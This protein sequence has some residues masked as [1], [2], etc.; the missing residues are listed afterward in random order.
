MFFVSVRPI[1]AT[2]FQAISPPSHPTSCLSPVSNPST[3]LPGWRPPTTVLSCPLPMA[4]RPHGDGPRPTDSPDRLTSTPAHP[5]NAPRTFFLPSAAI[6][7]DL[8]TTYSCV[9]VF[10]NGKVEI[11]GTYSQSQSSPPRS[12]ARV[13]PGLP[14]PADAQVLLSSAPLS[15]TGV[16]K[17]GDRRARPRCDRGVPIPAA[18]P[19]PDPDPAGTTRIA[20]CIPISG[21]L[22]TPVGWLCLDSHAVPGPFFRTKT[23]VSRDP[24]HPRTRSLIHGEGSGLDLGVSVIDAPVPKPPSTTDPRPQP[25]N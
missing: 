20:A 2:Q 16:C 21:Q 18:A 9:G 11:I 15:S 3:V 1:L 13:C 14:A 23:P 4:D 6:G 25:R 5:K 12:P 17:T 7:I 24:V 22:P 8:G 10:Q 19:T